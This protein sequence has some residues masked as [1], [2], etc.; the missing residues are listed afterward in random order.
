[1]SPRSF[2][3]NDTG[4]DNVARFTDVTSRA[5]G[6]ERCMV[7]GALWSDA[8]GDGWLDLLLSIEWG[9][10]KIFLNKEVGLWTRLVRL[11]LRL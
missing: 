3:R 4:D 2:L 9:P 7:T 11:A 10:V 8:N 6:L 5:K 1:M